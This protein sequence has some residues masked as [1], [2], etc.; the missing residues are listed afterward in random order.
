MAAARCLC[1]A[2][3]IALSG[4]TCSY[5]GSGRSHCPVQPHAAALDAPGANKGGMLGSCSYLMAD[6]LLRQGVIAPHD[7]PGQGEHAP[8]PGGPDPAPQYGTVPIGG[9]QQK[10]FTPPSWMASRTRW[11]VTSGYL[12]NLPLLFSSQTFPSLYAPVHAYAPP[13]MHLSLLISPSPSYPPSL[14]LINSVSPSQI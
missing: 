11:W 3:Q 8:G 12:V 9:P 2:M 13:D 14:P 5:Q 4:G 10:D 7:G 1:G 6:H